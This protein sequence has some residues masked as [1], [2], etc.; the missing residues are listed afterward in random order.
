MT[1]REYLGQAYRLKQWIRSL[2]QEINTMREM[3]VS[4]SSA[5]FDMSYNPNRATEAPYVKALEKIREYEEKLAVKIA[6]LVAI[7]N[8]ID[9]VIDRLED[10]DERMVLHYRYINNYSWTRIGEEM[11]ADSHTVRRW[12]DRALAH[13]Q[14]PEEEESLI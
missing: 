9:S 13:V 6:K 4:I 14:V 8:E 12:H 7:E 5:G 10:P 1:A 2:T 3:A 11:A